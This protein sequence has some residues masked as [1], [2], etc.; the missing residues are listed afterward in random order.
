MGRLKTELATWPN[1]VFIRQF[2][3]MMAVVTLCLPASQ[4]LAQGVPEQETNPVTEKAKQ[5][6]SNAGTAT[7]SNQAE[8]LRELEKMRARIQELE[9][10]LKQRSGEEMAE[11]SVQPSS[12]ANI[13]VP[14]SS[15]SAS[16]GVVEQKGADSKTVAVKAP[17]SEPFAFADWTWLNGNPRTKDAAFDSKFF[18]PE[19]RADIA[20]HYDFNH[21]QDDT[22]S[23]SSE[24][25]RFERSEPCSSRVS[26]GTFTTIM[27]VRAC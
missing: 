7:D 12:T 2:G 21:P 4:A 15:I 17:K 19:V 10:R 26:E 9:S 5:S 11:D 22:I 8:I 16:P 1:L 3:F 13:A 18:T 23:G 14:S 6:A 25:F 20:Y 24:V 27:S